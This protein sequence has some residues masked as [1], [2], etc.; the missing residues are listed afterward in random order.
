MKRNEDL[1][2]FLTA[3]GLIIAVVWH[4]WPALA[5]TAAGIIII[6]R[7]YPICRLPFQLR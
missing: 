5:L 3:A 7:E 1:N 2:Y 6:T 4:A